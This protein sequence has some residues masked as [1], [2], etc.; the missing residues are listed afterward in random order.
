MLQKFVEY[1]GFESRKVIK[2]LRFWI[3]FN[4]ERFSLKV[5]S[6]IRNKSSKFIGKG[7]FSWFFKEITKCLFCYPKYRK[8]KKFGY[9]FNFSCTY[10]RNIY[11]S[12]KDHIFFSR[13]YCRKTIILMEPFFLSIYWHLLSVLLQVYQYLFLGNK[14]LQK[15]L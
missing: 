4:E 8:S 1:L 10:G 12:P 15:P 11:F 7:K 9:W 2:K 3:S 13:F 6:I 5:L 14:Y